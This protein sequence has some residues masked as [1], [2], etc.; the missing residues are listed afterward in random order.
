MQP[1]QLSFVPT[2]TAH[3]PTRRSISIFSRRG[4]DTPKPTFKPL[5]TSITDTQQIESRRPSPWKRRL[6]RHDKSECHGTILH[7]VP[8]A[9][10]VSSMTPLEMAMATSPNQEILSAIGGEIPVSQPSVPDLP[11]SE[12]WNKS[13]NTTSPRSPNWRTDVSKIGVWR[14]GVALW[15]ERVRQSCSLAIPVTPATSVIQASENAARPNLSVVIP[16]E[17]HLQSASPR[18]RYTRPVVHNNS[19]ASHRLSSASGESAIHPAFRTNKDFLEEQVY[20][21]SSHKNRRIDSLTIS[22]ASTASSTGVE[23][24]EVSDNTSSYSRDSSMTSVEEEEAVDVIQNPDWKYANVPKRSVSAAFSIV[25]PV[26][27]GVFDE[28]PTPALADQTKDHLS[29][30]CQSSPTLSDV[31]YELETQLHTIPEDNAAF[32][33]PQPEQRSSNNTQAQ[34]CELSRAPTLPK[35]SRRRE[36]KASSATGLPPQAASSVLARP[37]SASDLLE[38]HQLFRSPVDVKRSAST[39]SA[40]WDAP[41]SEMSLGSAQMALLCSAITTL[42]YTTEPSVPTTPDDQSS[43]EAQAILLHIMSC[44]DSIDD[45]HAASM[46]NKGMRQVFKVNE[47]SLLR[48]VLKNKSPAAW[49]LREWSPVQFSEIHVGSG[50][51]HTPSSYMH[52]L[53]HD[54]SILQA[55]KVLILERGRS[56]LGNEAVAGLKWGD[57]VNSQRFD[58]A[59][60]RLWCF[61]KI[62]GCEKGREDDVTGQLDWLRGGL[63]AHQQDC[64][65][66]VNIN[67]E[68]DMGSVLLNA[69]DHF[70]MGNAGGLSASQLYD[71][72]ELWNCM[73]ALLSGYHG[74]IGHARNA[75]IYN[76]MDVPFGD[77]VQEEAVLE[78][79]MSYILTLG[80][81]VVVALAKFSDDDIDAGFR[82]AR[83][84]GWTEWRMPDSGNSRNTFFREPVAR[85]Y[86]ERLAAKAA[87]GSSQTNEMKEVGRKRVASLAAE[88]KLARNSSNYQRLPLIDMEHEQPMSIMSRRDS[89]ASSHKQSPPVQNFSRNETWTSRRVSPII[90]DRVYT[91]NR[92]SLLSLQGVAEDTAERAI[93][94]IV[95]M[96][97]PLQQAKDALRLTDMG[98]GLRVDK[99]VD[100]LLRQH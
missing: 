48:T 24:E 51:E 56:F 33:E 93:A 45:L 38:Q 89:A 80:P 73:A 22:R 78:E 97:F 85:L 53:R 23:Y 70:A 99:A 67:L 10:T 60:Y 59:F 100:L 83:L 62:F 65:A 91:F 3:R 96:G 86:E 49:E 20:Y 46:I 52:D 19:M 74:K 13:P 90:E 7:A 11:A 1:F 26:M 25:S 55:L 44:L 63:L 29:V 84:N 40:N 79:W 92:L 27:A 95:A 50:L 8:P 87:N 57:D 75:G 16:G 21:E 28:P 30:A 2:D 31:I 64:A 71:M 9:T 54:E 68:F 72:T 82:F 77:A 36:W 12:D 81:S 4:T 98:N 88:I 6:S 17:E 15:D 37:M 39:R 18:P 42:E 94:K 35:K 43:N 41:E 47:V 61:C 5:S 32:N 14:D 76:D 58:D 66:T 34:A 69:P